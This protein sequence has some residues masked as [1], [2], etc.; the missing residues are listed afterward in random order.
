MV[1]GKIWNVFCL[2]IFTALFFYLSFIAILFVFQSRL[3]YYPQAEVVA[4][5]NALRL[6]YETISFEAEDGVKLS[7]WF[8][9]AKKSRGV[10]LFCHGNA[11]NISHRLE[12]I[13]LFHHLG[14]STFIFDYR[15][16]G[17]SEGKP[18]EKGTYL[19]AEAAWRYLVQKQK[20]AS[21]EIIIFGRSLGG[22]IAAYLAQDHTPRALILESTFT[23][24][25][26]MAS[27]IY[28]FIPV[29]LLLRFH[30]HTTEYL[31]RV[32]CPL[33]VI[34]SPEDDMIPFSMGRRLFETAKEPKEFLE[35]SG[36][37]NEGFI[38]S[39]KMYKNGLDA[40]ISEYLNI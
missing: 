18:T 10:V 24:V 19:D 16:Y 7:G 25:R 37:H 34:H 15:G 30:Y 4:T 26:D 29:G 5:P 3:I 13:Q 17:Q 31:Q 1:I 40:F 14:L 8:I 22:A 12:S 38:I 36:D 2:L 9:P 32:N 27:A 6:S 33:L 39:A 20:V 21:T 11:G 28:P 23:S 35:I